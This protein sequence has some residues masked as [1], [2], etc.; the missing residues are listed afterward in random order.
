MIIEK[1]QLK[2]LSSQMFDYCVIGTGPA[3][4]TVALSL[5]ETGKKNLATRRW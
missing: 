3:G 4:M 2:A 5:E 1:G